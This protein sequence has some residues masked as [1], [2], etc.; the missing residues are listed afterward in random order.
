MVTSVKQEK[1]TIWFIWGTVFGMAL[2]TVAFSLLVII[3]PKLQNTNSDTSD[4]LVEISKLEEVSLP[5]LYRLEEIYNSDW[6]EPNLV[7][8]ALEGC[9]YCRELTQFLS[10][11][12]VFDMSKLVVIGY[13]S[14]DVVENF[15]Q[16]L[17]S[18]HNLGATVLIDKTGDYLKQ[19]HVTEFPQLYKVEKGGE[20]GWH[21]SG[22]PQG[23]STSDDL[24]GLLEKNLPNFYK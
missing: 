8:F 16:E 15:Q 2:A 23:V 19:H 3:L 14:S 7:F 10:E 18:L 9:P 6:Q 17:M 20:V 22:F 21:I 4:T 12:N 13:P 24:R 1:S 11:E 5:N